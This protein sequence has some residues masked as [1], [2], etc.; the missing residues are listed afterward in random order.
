[1]AEAL[2]RSWVTEWRMPLAL[3]LA[4]IVQT[5]VAVAFMSDFRARTDERLGSIDKATTSLASA[6]ST[7]S[8]T[9]GSNSTKV[10][11]L[12]AVAKERDEQMRSITHSLEVINEALVSVRE[13]LQIPGGTGR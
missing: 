6:I 2:K 5:V 11:V 9:V 12:E 7:I 10:A 1:M 3:V 13:R 4:I 8:T